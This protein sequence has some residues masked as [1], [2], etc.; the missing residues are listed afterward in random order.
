MDSQDISAALEVLLTTVK[1]S[2]LSA[3]ACLSALVFICY[4]IV[5]LFPEELE[6][7]WKIYFVVHSNVQESHEICKA[8][9]Y[10]ILFFGPAILSP[11]TN[12]ILAI[13][14]HALYNRASWVLYSAGTLILM[15]IAVQFYVSAVLAPK[16]VETWFKAPPGVPIYGC[17]STANY[18]IT[19]VAWL[20]CLFI[21]ATLF[22]M[23]TWK[24]ITTMKFRREAGV[25]IRLSPLFK[26]FV[27]SGSLYFLLLTP[28]HRLT[29]AIAISSA[30][31]VRVHNPL[32]TTYQPYATKK[33]NVMQMGPRLILDI[34]K[35]SQAEEVSTIRSG[36]V[37]GAQSPKER[38]EDQ[39]S[40]E[41]SIGSIDNA[42]NTIIVRHWGHDHQSGNCD[43]LPQS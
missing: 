30:I 14:V 26:G 5:L 12:V 23:M 42:R 38:S 2:H 3:Y 35:A 29:V 41:A 19:L 36:L 6:Y 39:R 34:R 8:W 22:L 24:V 25:G 18:D 15:E 27:K 33:L 28:F 16:S 9:F 4:D 43:F 1:L 17:L 7:I 10:G 11:L 37:F 31:S 21:A 32:V 13:R 20:P 40:S